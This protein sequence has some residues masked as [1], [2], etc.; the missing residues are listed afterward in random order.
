MKAAFIAGQTK[1]MPLAPG[2]DSAVFGTGRPGGD[3]GQL[4][5]A[6]RL[7]GA[8][9]GS[10]PARGVRPGRGARHHRRREGQRLRPRR[11]RV[12]R[13]CARRRPTGWRLPTSRKASSCAKRVHGRILVFGALSVSDLAGVFSHDFT[14]TVSSPARRPRRREARA[15]GAPALPPE[16]RHRPQSAGISSRQPAADPP[17]LLSSRVGDRGGLHPLRDRRRAGTALFEAQRRSFRG[18]R[19][20]VTPLAAAPGS[21]TRPTARRRCAIPGV[22]RSR[23]AGIVALRPRAAAAGDDAAVTGDVAHQSGGRGERGP[24]RR[25]SV[26]AGDSRRRRDA[27]GDSGRLRRWPRPATRRSRRV[28]VRGRRAPIVG[29]VS[30]DM[31][32]VDVTDIEACRPATKSS[33][34]ARRAPRRG[35]QST[36]AR[37]HRFARFLTRFCVGSER[38]WRGATPLAATD[39]ADADPLPLRRV[40]PVAAR[41]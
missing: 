41:P 18:R 28:L 29:A 14:P 34:S 37:W 23:S 39:R 19:K 4:P 35:K 38:A 27:G 15:R 22:G 10:Q 13:L 33:F 31:L 6:H 12:A 2:C 30:M 32:T 8:R 26:T 7:S 9:G 1:F 25:A 17:E 3:P 11:G 40:H 16:D 5:G 20:T 36:R 21:C 24:Q